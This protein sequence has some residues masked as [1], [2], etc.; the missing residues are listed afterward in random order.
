MYDEFNSF[1]NYSLALT[2]KYVFVELRVMVL[3]LVWSMD[4]REMIKK[5]KNQSD[6][7]MDG[8]TESD[9]LLN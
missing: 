7:E 9:F 6:D 5:R 2:E 8:R 1:I 3:C 4:D